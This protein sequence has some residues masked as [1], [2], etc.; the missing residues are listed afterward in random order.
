MDSFARLNKLK[1]VISYLLQVRFSFA[2]NPFQSRSIVWELNG[3]H[4]GVTW[5]LQRTC[6]GFTSDLQ[7][8]TLRCY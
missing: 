6:I 1:Q 3:S 7:K 4:M 2:S 8:R 5:D